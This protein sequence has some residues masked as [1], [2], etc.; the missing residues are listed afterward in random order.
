[1]T[2]FHN[3][4]CAIILFSLLGIKFL[5]GQVPQLKLQGTRASMTNAYNNTHLPLT[6]ASAYLTLACITL[7]TSA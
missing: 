2:Q 5:G 4:T 1:M 7:L 6:I 3:L